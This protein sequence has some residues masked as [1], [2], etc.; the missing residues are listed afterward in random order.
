[1]ASL[2]ETFFKVYKKVWI[3]AN[4]EK[5][6]LL[7]ALFRNIVTGT[8][9]PSEQSKRLLSAFSKMDIQP[10]DSESDVAS[11]I[12]DDIKIS[13]IVKRAEDDGKVEHVRRSSS[14]SMRESR[15]GD[16]QEPR[17]EGRAED[18]VRG[19]ERQELRAEVRGEVRDED[20]SRA[21]KRSRSPSAS[22]SVRPQKKSSIFQVFQFMQLNCPINHDDF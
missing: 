10:S 6:D 7:R 20:R 8:I 3:A 16:R 1:M 17:A 19:G 12:D 14:S 22:L 2:I 5:R 21:R 11:M 18:R 9:I 15:G 4:P 13:K